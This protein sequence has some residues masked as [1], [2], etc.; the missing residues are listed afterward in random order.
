MQLSLGFRLEPPFDTSETSQ[1]GVFVILGR[2][3]RTAV[4]SKQ[5]HSWVGSVSS[6]IEG[7][8]LRTAK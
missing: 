8:V 5:R 4:C 6:I 1:P 3:P 2:I 7:Y